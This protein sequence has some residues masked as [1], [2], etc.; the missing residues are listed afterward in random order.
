M[1]LFAEALPFAIVSTKPKG[2][3][4]VLPDTDIVIKEDAGDEEAELLAGAELA[5]AVVAG[6]LSVLACALS[7]ATR[8][9]VLHAAGLL[10]PCSPC[11]PSSILIFC[12]ASFP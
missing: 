9:S 7:G 2:I 4:Q 10:L 12:P 5:P 3:V 11:Q 8:V 6:L 1:T